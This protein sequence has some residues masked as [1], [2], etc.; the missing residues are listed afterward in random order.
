MGGKAAM[1]GEH[2][3][4]TNLL[5]RSWPRTSCVAERLWAAADV[6]NITEAEPR[7]H[8]F[9]CHLLRRGI[10]AEPISPGGARKGPDGQ[11]VPVQAVNAPGFCEPE[12]DPPYAPSQGVYATVA[13]SIV[14]IF[15]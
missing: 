11:T 4:S 6:N 12:F 8:N 13:F 9:R 5:S 15:L 3:D 2:V 14:N 10:P 1:W 7:L